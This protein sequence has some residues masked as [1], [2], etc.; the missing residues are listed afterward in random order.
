MFSFFG[1]Q[2][3]DKIK[4]FGGRVKMKNRKEIDYK[5]FKITPEFA[6]LHAHICGDG[7]LFKSKTNR[8]KS[9]YVC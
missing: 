7:C 6:R 3:L 8:V 5:K 2:S 4:N 9:S 1:L